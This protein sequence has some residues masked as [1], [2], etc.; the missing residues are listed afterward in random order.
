MIPVP[1]SG[2]VESITCSLVWF[3]EMVSPTK[4]QTTKFLPV[5]LV[6]LG[7]LEIW[8]LVPF[9]DRWKY[10][11]EQYS[12]VLQAG[13]TKFDDFRGQPCSSGK[14]R[15]RALLIFKFCN[16]KIRWLFFELTTCSESKL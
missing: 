15:P 11:D 6:V 8:R 13:L 16:F 1:K 9:T 5:K 3:E 2:G 4:S 7:D 14:E 12:K 10:T